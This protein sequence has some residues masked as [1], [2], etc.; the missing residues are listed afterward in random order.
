MEGKSLKD[1]L[2]R[3]IS[4]LPIGYISKKNIRGTTCYYRQWKENGKLKSEY[5]NPN[6]IDYMISLIDERRRLQLELRAETYRLNLSSSSQRR[7]YEYAKRFHLGRTIGIGHQDYEVMI[8]DKLFYVD[9]TY[10]IQ[11]WWNHNDQVTLITR[12]RRFGKTLNLSMI[13]CFFSRKYEGR[14]D[15]FEGMDV[16]KNTA[17]HELQGSQPVIFLSFGDIKSS[18]A[19]GQIEQIKLLLSSVFLENDFICEYLDEASSQIFRSYYTNISKEMAIKG[20][21]VLCELMYKAFGKKVIILL[22]E[23]DTPMLEAWTAGTW[24]ECSSFMRLFFNATLKSNPYLYRALLTGI[25]RISK[26]SFFSDMNNLRVCSMTSPEYD[27]A[28]GF[29]EKEVFEAMDAQKMSNKD[30][31]KY[32]YNG[33]SIGRRTDIYNPWSIVNFLRDRKLQSYWVHTSS[34]EMINDLF[35]RGDKTLKY[36]L[37]D[38]INGQ[39]VFTHMNEE[40]PFGQIYEDNSALWSLLFACGYMK[41]VGTSGNCWNKKYELAV[42]NREVYYMLL[43]FI[44]GWF[45]NSRNGYSDFVTAM[46]C[47]DVEYMTEYLSK[48]CNRVFSYYDTSGDE[49]ERFYHGFVLGMLVDLEDRFIIT[50]NRESGF[51]RY[52]VVLE[53]RN[54][55]IDPAI[56]MEFKVHRPRKEADLMTTAQNALQQIKEKDYEANL[57]SHSISQDNIYKYGIAFKGKEVWIESGN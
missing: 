48:I 44:K 22:D 54:C 56:I 12:P 9:K 41:I 5:I 6:D 57:I 18:S 4:E 3:R 14:S 15:L 24:K 10:F 16:W 36:D 55:K 11:D 50:S 19:S 52:D 29:T 37:E 21:C 49:P 28:F 34:N 26:E 17:M 7:F 13:N 33:F 38:L 8:S 51:G 43:E 45:S 35:K 30:E 2:E 40:T 1:K 39:H 23:Y 32:W 46:L 47:H 31:V 53:P 42:T 27:Y 20:I 25:T